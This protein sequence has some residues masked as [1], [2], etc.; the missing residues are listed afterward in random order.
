MSSVRYV[1][2]RYQGERGTS[3]GQVPR[4]MGTSQ[5]KFPGVWGSKFPDPCETSSQTR[6]K[7]VPGPLW[8][9]FPDPWEL[10]SQTQVPRPLGTCPWGV[11]RGCT[12]PPRNCV[13][14]RIN[15]TS[16]TPWE[17]APGNFPGVREVASQP[18]V[19]RPLGSKFPGTGEASSQTPGKFS[20]TTS[21]TPGKLLPRP[22]G[23]YPWELGSGNI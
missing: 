8:S 2:F 11:P 9:K 6:V 14:T 19:P 5:G 20:G 16:Q 22:L 15:S 21:Q 17:L 7:Q 1:K 13:K 4:P 12:M 23:T 10:A 18:Q 3:Q